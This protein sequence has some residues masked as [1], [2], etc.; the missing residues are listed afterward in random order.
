MLSVAPETQALAS[1]VLQA[2]VLIVVSFFYRQSVRAE[3]S[4][5]RLEGKLDLYFKMQSKPDTF[6]PDSEMVA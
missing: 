1:V 4:V 5:E 2:V 3:R 6:P